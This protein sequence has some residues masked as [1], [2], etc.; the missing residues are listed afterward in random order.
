MKFLYYSTA[1]HANHGGSI[2]SIE[3]F[4]HLDDFVAIEDKK[5]FPVSMPT[6]EPKKDLKY[7]LRLFLRKIPLL[8]ILF[9]YRRNKM[10]L[11][12]LEEFIDDYKPDVLML[13]IDSNFLQI[14]KLKTRY[15]ELLVITQVN[16]SPFDEPFKNIAFKKHFLRRQQIMYA[17]A[18]FNFFV[19]NFLRTRIMGNKLCEMRDIVVHNG[20]D[21]NKFKPLNNKKILREIFNYPEDKILLGYIGTLDHHKKMDLLINSLNNL[22]AE[23][24]DLV[25]VIIGDGPGMAQIKS[26]IT[27]LDLHNKVILKG[28]ID[29]DSINDH[30]NCFDIAIHHQANDYMSPLKLFEYLAAGLPVIGPKIPAVEEIFEDSYEIILTKAKVTDITENIGNLL[31]NKK[32]MESLIKLGPEIIR[33]KYTWHFYTKSIIQKIVD[34][35]KR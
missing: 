28:W 29:H 31:N 7:K 22:S 13:Q 15:P 23:N 19:S 32:K 4:N 10:Y 11:L 14:E 5:V 34:H 18:D 1:Y 30:L 24:K 17:Q 9:F 26:L 21:I 8:Q 2:Q 27:K 6:I 33:Q 35:E 16:G 3:F 20:T 25:L 12:K